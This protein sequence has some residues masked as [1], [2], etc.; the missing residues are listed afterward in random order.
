MIS[1]FTLIHF[2]V[3]TVHIEIGT[4]SLPFKRY[5]N[6]MCFVRHVGAFLKILVI[7]FQAFFISLDLLLRDCGVQ[8][9]GIVLIIDWSQF[10]LGQVS[11]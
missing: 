3:V 7:S 10:S 5:L 1:T 4:L 8:E 9:K 2:F 11:K 6:M